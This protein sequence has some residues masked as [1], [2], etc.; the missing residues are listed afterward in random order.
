MKLIRRV[1]II[2]NLLYILWILRNGI[3]EGFK[4]TPIHV[5]SYIGI[6]FLLALNAFLLSRK[7]K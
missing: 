5:V 3:D 1:A 6:I 2:G 4:A 7:N